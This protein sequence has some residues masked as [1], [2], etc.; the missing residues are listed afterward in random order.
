M[1]NISYKS[2][3]GNQNT[4]FNFMFSNFVFGNLVEKKNCRAGQATDNYGACELH[5]GYLRLQTHAQNM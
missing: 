4:H 3:R 2:C 5:A 1:R